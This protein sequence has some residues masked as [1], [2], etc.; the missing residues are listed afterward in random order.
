MSDSETARRD[1][2]TAVY[3][4]LRDRGMDHPTAIGLAA[5]ADVESESNPYSQRSTS[6]AAG[7]F[8]WVGPRL[9]AYRALRGH[10]PEEGD[11][12][13]HLDHVV[14]ENQNAEAPAWRRV[15]QAPPDPVAKATTFR[16]AWERPGRDPEETA[17]E[18]R[19][20]ANSA[21]WLLGFIS[22]SAQAAEPS[23]T[24]AQS[25]EMTIAERIAIARK[26]GLNDQEIFQ[27]LSQS[28]TLAPL[29]QPA[30]DKGFN[31]Q[32]IFGHYGLKIGT[33]ERRSH[34]EDETPQKT[35]G[36]A[37]G[38]HYDPAAKQ[39]VMNPITE[40]T[41]EA[42]AL[43]PGYEDVTEG[44]MAKLQQAFGKPAAHAQETKASTGDD[45][46]AQGLAMAM[47][48]PSVT[49]AEVPAGDAK[50]WLWGMPGHEAEPMTVNEAKRPD[51]LGEHAFQAAKNAWENTQPFLDPKSQAILDNIQRS[52]GVKGYLAALGS[53][54]AHD[55]DYLRKTFWA[56]MAGSTDFAYQAL[57]KVVGEPGARTI[58]SMPD[59]FMGSP[60]PT[61][62]PPR[63]RL[64]QAESAAMREAKGWSE[65]PLTINP[66]AARPSPHS[67]ENAFQWQKD[68]YPQHDPEALPRLEG[69]AGEAPGAQPSAPGSPPPGMPPMPQSAGPPPGRPPTPESVGPRPLTPEAAAA[70]E[71][72]P[73]TVP[74]HPA[75]DGSGAMTNLSEADYATMKAQ[76]AQMPA[77][78]PLGPEEA[79]AITAL[80]N[81]GQGKPAT[82]AVARPTPIPMPAPESAAIPMPVPPQASDAA[83]GLHPDHVAVLRAIEDGNEPARE[84][85]PVV[86]LLR[87]LDLVG[88]REDGGLF[89]TDKGIAA[90]QR[91]EGLLPQGEE[92]IARIKPEEPVPV[93][94][95]PKRLI[96]FLQQ[97]VKIN[98]GT[99]SE[100]TAKFGLQDPGGDLRAIIGGTRERPGFINNK[101]GEA[102]DEA[103][104]RA[105]EAGYFDHRPDINELLDA[106]ASDNRGVPHYSMRDADAI[107]A[108]RDAVER[109]KEIARGDVPAEKPDRY[110]A[111]SQEE[112]DFWN[113]LPEDVFQAGRRL[114]K[115]PSPQGE[116]L[117]GAQ[118][119]QPARATPEP[120]IRSP[121]QQTLEGMEPS[122]RQA[123]AARD[124]QPPRSNQLPADQGLVTPRTET[125]Q[126]SLPEPRISRWHQNSGEN[127]HDM[128]TEAP[129]AG[130]ADAMNWV[131]NKGRDTGHEHIAVVDN[132]TGEIVHAGTNK[133][134]R[135]VGF[136]LTHGADAPGSLTVHHNHPNG[137]ALSG[138]DIGMLANPGTSHVVAHGHDG[139]TTVA[140]MAPEMSKDL[141]D[142]EKSIR[143]NA[144]MIRGLYNNALRRSEGIL[145]PL[146]DHGHLPI[147]DANQLYN[148][149]ANR[150][151]QAAGLIDYT[152]TIEVPPMVRTA[153]DA[154]VRS[155][156]LVPHDRYSGAVRPEERIA[157]LPAPLRDNGSTGGEGGGR[158]GTELSPD[159]SQG[160]FLEP[161]R[162]LGEPEERAGA[163]DQEALSAAPPLPMTGGHL[164]V[165]ILADKKGLSR[166][167]AE[168]KAAFS[169]TS[170]KGAQPL[171]LMLRKHGAEAALAYQRATIGLRHVRNA[172]DLMKKDD[173]IEFTDRMENGRSQPTP[174]LQKV[175]DMLRSILD[176]WT[177]KVQ[178]M[179]K[180]YLQQAV[181][182]YMGH[183]WGNHREWVAGQPAPH[184]SQMTGAA[185][186]SS[187]ARSPLKGS[188]NFLKPRTFLT[189]KDG[190]NA[191]LVPVTYNP[192][193]LQLLKLREIQKFY[194]GERLADNMR[195]TGMAT[196]VRKADQ[197]EAERRGYV[198]LDDRVFQPQLYGVHAAG[199]VSPGDYYAIEPQARLFNRYMSAGI[200]GKS[201]WYDMARVAGNALNSMQL[202]WPGFHTSFVTMDTANSRFALGLQQIAHGQP[203]KGTTNVAQS[204][205]PGVAMARALVSGSK[206]RKALIDPTT[207]TPEYRQLAD[208]MIMGGGRLNMDSFY[209]SAASGSFIHG[210]GDFHPK[211]IASE[212][213]Q[214]YRDT[215][216]GWRKAVVPP[217]Q[218]AFRTL[219]TIMHPLMG[220]MVPRAKLGVFSEQAKAWHAS[221]PNPTP[222]ERA[223]AMTTIWDNV[224]DRLGQMTYNNIFW[225]K[226]LKDI[227]H[228][229]FRSVGWNLGT[230]RAGAGALVDAGHFVADAARLRKPEFTGRMTYGISQFANTA[231][232]GAVLTYLFTG[233]GPDQWLDYFFPP[234]GGETAN[235]DAERVA[236]PGYIKDWIEWTHDPAQTALNKIHPAASLLNQVRTNRDYYGGIINDP[237]RD[238]T[239]VAYGDFIA[240]SMLPFTVTGYHKLSTEGASDAAKTLS[241]MGFQPAPKSIVAPERGEAF[242]RKDNLKAFKRRN[243]EHGRFHFFSENPATAP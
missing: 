216:P 151:L 104:Q 231:I 26:A 154:E 64:T 97:G 220:L 124:A 143:K 233:R 73:P 169:P 53:T 158:P 222:E 176:E 72:V 219:D 20:A 4:G 199:P 39:L 175:A 127:F 241:L 88:V 40:D 218:I 44:Q 69:P 91:A 213:A 87:Y 80:E 243:K 173:L 130:H 206:T 194:Y 113:S 214:L 78:A 81:I 152:S 77:T 147:D 14:W 61:G 136:G 41:P 35:Y 232:L 122:A 165:D 33:L 170:L 221:N 166:L 184:S 239:L 123:Q 187:Q 51:N 95:E 19:K 234:T 135:E 183:I 235:G 144:V 182:D 120:T 179:G 52:G 30:R 1:R 63:P 186:A 59:A 89:V 132:R 32:Q 137:S 189:Q 202:A 201:L 27:R 230:I 50:T 22:P 58:M 125:T 3:Q 119:A 227:S 57:S 62:M 23:A 94:K 207:A 225:H 128:L 49:D 114:P 159:G 121:R 229:M 82:P 93:P 177:V 162:R 129:T 66:D 148:D 83:T 6:G 85:M 107:N 210:W 117:F 208:D 180:G 203:I 11:L 204:V 71:N 99:P 46:A 197:P 48:A 168:A 188:G 196:W 138:P 238:S 157:G 224:E 149:L 45:A 185:N 226:A 215:P 10:E 150:I 2:A 181:D 75:P 84:Q 109:N 54:A 100:R 5:N 38:F 126:P 42:T 17:A 191:G 242:Q 167:V 90:R 13:E 155:R 21:R 70:A 79:A 105:Y 164:N 7:T 134:E 209:N 12:D 115:P 68:Y 102:L 15:Q 161:R 55:L 211:H 29:F 106:I 160:A 56:G 192:V 205:V 98:E 34:D 108:Y 116:D 28:K 200:A 36:P 240:N 47:G 171:E 178:A 24:T 163:L 172:L 174:E 60:R 131:F 145:R 140:S 96:P 43:P 195:Q 223:A 139:T 228:L 18:E 92:A 146:V 156:G 111:P 9:T 86:T 67:P 236:I 153:L 133:K 142:D 112:T 25:K 198:K 76:V 110:V 103:G 237:D 8:Q 141:A 16:T 217:L 31:D 74:T 118:R 37:P 193:D 190:I 101:T 65:A 212:V